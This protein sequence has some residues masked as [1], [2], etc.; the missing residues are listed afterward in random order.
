[1]KKKWLL[2]LF[3]AAAVACVSLVGCAKPNKNKIGRAHV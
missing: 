1:M 2:P 3:T